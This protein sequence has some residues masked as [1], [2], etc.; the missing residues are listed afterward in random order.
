MRKILPIFLMAIFLVG[1]NCAFS[2]DVSSQRMTDLGK[3]AFSDG[4]YDDALHYFERAQELDP[5]N[6]EPL[7]YINLIKRVDED[8]VTVVREQYL[9]KYDN[10]SDKNEQPNPAVQEPAS[11]ALQ[12]RISAMDR[13][14]D[15]LENK[16]QPQ[17]VQT[18][19]PAS[20]PASTQIVSAEQGGQITP[21]IVVGETAQVGKP[22][23]QVIANP[24][25][26]PRGVGYT[27]E[28]I[29]P[30]QNRPTAQAVEKVIELKPENAKLF[31][32]DVEIFPNQSFIVRAMHVRRYL[33]V[34]D[35]YLQVDRLDESSIRV[36]GLTL[37]PTVFYVWDDSTRWIFKV[38]VVPISRMD[39]AQKAWE[40]SDAFKF[41]YDNN[42]RSYYKGA[43]WGSLARNSL[44][45]DEDV[46]MSGPTPYGDFDSS[47]T[48]SNVG[49]DEKIKG[50]TVGLSSGHFLDFNNFNIRGFDFANAFSPLSFPGTT[51]RGVYFN[52]PAINHAVE[53]T[54]IEGSDLRSYGYLSS[55]LAN[56]EK[57]FI[58][59]VQAK[60]FPLEKNSFIF[61]YA[62]G[63]GKDRETDLKDHVYSVES[64]HT[65]GN[66]SILNEA[67]YDGDGTAI[68]SSWNLRLPKVTFHTS[69]RDID[70]QFLTISGRPANS[71]EVGGNLG[72]DWRPNDKFYLSSDTD[73]Y[74][75]R[76]NYNNGNSDR[77]NYDWTA[78]SGYNF[79]PTLVWTNNTYYSYNPELSFPQRNLSATT[80][81][82]KNNTVNILGR[83]SLTMY[84]G[85]TYQKSQNTL[86][87]T[88]DYL[89]NSL[90]GGSRL[91]LVDNLYLY[92]TYTYSWLDEL[93]SGTRSN[94][95]VLE[96]GFDYNKDITKT[97][98]GNYRICY[99]D[100][101]DAASVHSFLA[102]E[103]SLEGSMSLSYR[104]SRDVQFFVDGR[105]RQVWP[106]N[107]NAQYIEADVRLGTKI[108]WDSF[109]K[110]SPSVEVEGYVFKDL[111][112][113]GKMEK[114]EEPIAGARINIGPQVAVSDKNGK[115]RAVVRAKAVTATLDINT[116]SKGYVL[117]T[118]NSVRIDTSRAGKH[119]VNFGVSSQSG[120]YGVVFYDV[121]GDGK[122]DRNDKP[123]AKV[124]MMLDGKQIAM[125][126]SD[127]VYFFNGLKPGKYTI[128]IDVN[129]IPLQYLPAVTIRRQIEVTEG[130]TSAYHVP[131]NKR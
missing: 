126:N 124:R 107:G 28:A 98:S 9:S 37:G 130:V 109:F 106:H 25:A 101:D 56:N 40:E 131:L 4:N 91:S 88:S 129:S 83:H 30:I 51:L 33:A 89:R 24:T 45:F 69:F 87:P 125:T 75:D 128:S 59:G 49:H 105:L 26:A 13:T 20:L 8:R 72:F 7:Y 76:Q 18:A 21:G 68:T 35:G 112:S 84:S 121:N 65:L 16:A 62:R 94:P 123:I 70:K 113:N 53:Y 81:L 60:L 92:G 27:T 42:W 36:R 80:T 103:D 12:G 54:Y 96:A 47:A 127:G 66:L 10:N 117:T 95:A 3:E 22:A 78:S 2:F 110:W 55:G 111:N 73:I 31:P 119:L 38:N 102:G 61:N 17:A 82:T 63:Y 85:Y 23:Y 71:G 6:K 90:F 86:S 116:I 93:Q 97:I 46:G 122:F 79:T 48:W 14:L 43:D 39:M 99:R 77:V 29:V 19:A 11:A 115:F 108:L 52:S 100:E 41:Y 50:Y 67:A 118:P 5:E 32:L 120:L 57:S 44:I 15:A 64:R 74:R 114:G 34:N 1:G 58:E 104:P